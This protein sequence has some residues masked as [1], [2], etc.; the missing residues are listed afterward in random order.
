MAKLGPLRWC[1]RCNARLRT[2]EGTGCPE[3][4]LSA[5]VFE[6]VDRMRREYL[7]AAAALTAAHGAAV[8]AVVRRDP[9]TRS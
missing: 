8:N 9:D 1:P 6:T 2:P 3:C 5:V 4:G 7:A